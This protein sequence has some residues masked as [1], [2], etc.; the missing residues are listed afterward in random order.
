MRNRALYVIA[1]VVLLNG[2]Q[3]DI[4]GMY[5]ASDK[6]AVCWLQLVRTPDNHLTGQLDASVLGSDGK[7]ERSSMS[8]AGA[9]DGENVTLSGSV[10]LGLQPTTLS[11]TLDGNSLTLTGIQA[12][13]FILKRSRLSDYQTQLNAL[14]ARSQAILA[15]KESANVRQR[16]AQVLQFLS[17][18]IDQA[19]GDMQ[20]FDSEA[21]MHLSR[22]PGAEEQ[23][24]AITEKVAQYVNR[25]HQLQGHPNASVVRGQ[26]N[27]AANQAA[28]A[29]D[30]LHNS[31]LSFQFNLEASEKP[32]TAKVDHLEQACHVAVSPGDLTAAQ[33]DERIDACKQLS[34]AVTAFRQKLVALSTGLAHLEQVYVTEK[35]SQQGLIRSAQRL[36]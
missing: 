8:L 29:T 11:G 24:R 10:S 22:L 7:V 28:I 36:Y 15:A 21:D 1:A 17:S 3:R 20:K 33:N 23:Y 6:A 19:V 35:S 25:E 26:L 4:S 18:Q 30:Q 31:A 2:C 5:L 27:V 34:L 14:N 12:T 16:T 32:L 13:P 9:V